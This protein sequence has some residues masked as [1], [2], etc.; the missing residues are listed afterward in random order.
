MCF[1]ARRRLVALWEDFPDEVQSHQPVVPFQLDHGAVLHNL[2]IARRAAPGPSGMT[3]EHLRP[4]VG[5]R[6]RWSFALRFG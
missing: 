1:P 5:P 6:W 2:R 3:S 4:F